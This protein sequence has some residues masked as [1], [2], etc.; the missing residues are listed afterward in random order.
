MGLGDTWAVI[1]QRPLK[2]GSAA[3]AA[4]AA[5]HRSASDARMAINLSCGTHARFGIDCEYS[6]FRT[7]A[8]FATHRRLAANRDQSRDSGSARFARV[9]RCKQLHR[10]GG[11]LLLDRDE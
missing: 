7:D 11:E 8:E 4:V 1:S 6:C 2:S 10:L 5:S 9:D 3:N